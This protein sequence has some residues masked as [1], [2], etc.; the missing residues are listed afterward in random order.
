MG[1]WIESR[2]NLFKLVMCAAMTPSYL[3]NPLML[4]ALLIPGMA[5]YF[6]SFA[7]IA[8]AARRVVREKMEKKSIEE[9][10]KSPDVLSKLFDIV[11][12][13]GHT[14]EFSHPEITIEAY[15]AIMAG[16]DSTAS[17][18]RTV[19][20]FLMKDPARYRKAADEVQAA[21]AKGLL[22]TPIKYSESMANLPYVGVCIKKA[23]RI[24]PPFAVRMSRLAPA[25]RMGLCGHYI[26]AGYAMGVNAAVVQ[27]DNGVFGPDAAEFKPERWLVP[28]EQRYA[29]ER[30]VMWFGGGTRICVGK[31]VRIWLVLQCGS[32]WTDF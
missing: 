18:M 32:L 15:V 24:L 17:L 2:D 27:L 10:I 29:M 7:T 21:D 3:M 28:P 20:Y 25:Q 6:K 13:R 26:P 9:V 12:S 5:E 16:A 11:N 22:S 14:A 4:S 30:A 1:G 8:E 19:F 31:N 23:G